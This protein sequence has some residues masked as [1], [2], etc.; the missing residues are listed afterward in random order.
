MF[1]LDKSGRIT[2]KWIKE[3]DSRDF[4]KLVLELHIEL[5]LS[6]STQQV[7]VLQS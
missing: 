5:S 3:C 1:D 4:C 2:S 7:C 6:E